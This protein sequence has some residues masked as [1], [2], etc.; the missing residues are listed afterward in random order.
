M[1]KYAVMVG[2]VLMLVACNEQVNEETIKP[3]PVTDTA[4]TEP[5]GG[6]TSETRE[7]EGRDDEQVVIP[8][9]QMDEEDVEVSDEVDEPQES[10]SQEN[11][12]EDELLMWIYKMEDWS[13]YSSLLRI[14]NVYDDEQLN[15]MTQQ[16]TTYVWM[17][18]QLYTV[19]QHAGISTTLIEQYMTEEEAYERLNLDEWLPLEGERAYSP[20]PAKMSFF[21]L[22]LESSAYTV[23]QQNE[24]AHV[25]FTVQPDNIA[26]VY[27]MLQRA[28]NIQ[29]DETVTAE[30]IYAEF[31]YEDRFLQQYKITVDFDAAEDDMPKELVIDEAFTD[32]NQVEALP[33]RDTL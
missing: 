15:T 7:S 21:E 20:L 2:A 12:T 23:E 3:T 4:A 13:G 22:M 16:E 19:T 5:V 14:E 24:A 33:A 8:E 25:T 10:V 17:P 28:F 29:M 27:A 11:V 26:Y 9:P 1:R 30:D 32:M 6:E 31:H 18:E